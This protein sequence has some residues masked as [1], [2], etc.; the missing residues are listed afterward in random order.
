[1]SC[2]LTVRETDG[3]TVIDVSGR[4]TLGGGAASLREMLHGLTATRQRNI[5][6]NLDEVTHMDSSG[7]GLLVSSFASIA[8]NGGTL[9][10][11]NLSPKIKD[12]LLITKLYTVF[13][14][15]DDE[16]VAI[17]SFSGVQRVHA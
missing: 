8:R 11:V 6:L 14:V 2:K 13:E 10:L 9:K 17:R 1:M 3:V 5:L 15:H 4:L 7:I 16:A 12:L